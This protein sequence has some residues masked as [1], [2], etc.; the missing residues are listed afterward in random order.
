MKVIDYR[1]VELKKV[2]MEGAVSASIRRVLTPT[3]GTPNFAMRI[4]ELGEGGCTPQHAHE[5]E[6]EIYCIEGKGV[7]VTDNGKQ[8]DLTPGVAALVEP[9]EL[10]QFKNTS[11][12]TLKFMCLVP[13]N[14][15]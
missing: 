15:A 6:H 7:I 11:K 1:D 5:W 14:Y 8:I 12:E 3:D 9:H 2:E 10:H 13:N 4:F